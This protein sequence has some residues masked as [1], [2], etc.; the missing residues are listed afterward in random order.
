[1]P[2]MNKLVIDNILDLKDIV[3]KEDTT[4]ID[5]LENTIGTIH[6]YVEDNVCLY[7]VSMFKKTKN[8]IIYHIGK[9]SKVIVNKIAIDNSDELEVYLDNCYAE[10][11]LNTGIINYKNNTLS[12]KVYHNQ[13]YTKSNITNHAINFANNNLNIDVDVVIPKESYGSNSNQDNKIIN[14][15]S[16]KNEIKP[17]LIVD[18]NEIEASHSAYI[19]KFD[20][21]SIFYLMT[22]GL[23]LEMIKKLLSIG[24]LLN[25]MDLNER[26]DEV[27]V[28]INQN[29]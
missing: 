5:K 6:I 18:N 21:E 3:I 19:G 15:G 12:E 13:D 11:T 4:L 24:F 28:F 22:R 10:F 20:K 8:K 9:N 23:S 1:M 16:G 2:K 7:E 17:N 27:I 29:I 26:K 14:F 25:K